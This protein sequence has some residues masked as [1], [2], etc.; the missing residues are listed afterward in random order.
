MSCIIWMLLKENNVW[1]NCLEFWQRRSQRRADG[2]CVLIRASAFHSFFW[3]AC[4]CFPC[5]CPFSLVIFGFVYVAGVAP[6]DV[7]S[8]HTHHLLQRLPRQPQRAGQAHQ[9][10]G[11]FPHCLTEPRE[12]STRP[13][14][15]CHAHP[16]THLT[17]GVDWN[18]TQEQGS[19]YP[20][21]HAA[22][23]ESVFLLLHHGEGFFHR[24]K[25]ALPKIR[26][27]SQY[28]LFWDDKIR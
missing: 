8:F 19:D 25:Y 3:Y 16:G 9:W 5:R 23:T 27:S 2:V 1:G 6:A 11:A 4:D 28:V 26:I 10:R 7:W 14:T 24:S 15:F 18:I 12:S 22:V 17:G 21:T 20:M 13:R